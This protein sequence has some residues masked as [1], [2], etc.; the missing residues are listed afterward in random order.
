VIL[1]LCCA[2]APAVLAAQQTRNQRIAA[3]QQAYQNFDTERAL[4]LLRGA[5]NPAEGPPDSAWA[6]G[7]ELL[8]QIVSEAGD[9]A[10]AGVWFRWAFRTA[11]NIPIDTINFLPDVFRAMRGAR[12]GITASTGDAVTRTTYQWAAPGAPAGQG[13]FQVV[14]PRMTAPV[15]ALAQGRIGVQSGQTITVAAGTYQ[16]QGAAEGYLPAQITREVLPGV[17][18]V[19][20]FNL[21]PVS[22]AVLSSGAR[23]AAYRALVPLTVRRFGSDSACVTGALVSGSGLV[24]TSYAAI[25]GAERLSAAVGTQRYG[26]E[27]RVLV[28]DPARNLAVLQLPVARP[29]SLPLAA[30]VTPGQF[31]WAL[32]LAGCQTALDTRS[33]VGNAIQPALELTDS[34]RDAQHVG[35]V[36][37]SD[38][39][40]V[41]L[42]TGARAAA[43]LGDV[44]AIVDSARRQIAAREKLTAAQ[45]ALRTNHAYGS[46]AITADVTGMTARVTPLETWQWPAV[47]WSGTLPHTFAGPM[48]RYQLEL[49]APGQAPRRL[50]FTIRPG[51]AERFPVTAQV[52]GGPGPQ[53]P[54]AK[55]KGG[56]PLPI[57]LIGAGG[58]GAAAFLL[59]GGKSQ[60]QQQQQQP[61]TGSLIILI[62]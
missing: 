35:A 37:G 32:G 3:A 18:T 5:V 44:R 55:K 2:L 45:V 4:E 34:V 28:W 15:N 53:V 10:Q 20:E 11:A 8:G 36:I 43:P 46:M 62:P 47:S 14:S 52:V 60:Q 33:Q 12:A 23:A 39:A 61:T 17:T 56:F 50:T 24:L 7:I 54:A 13:R 19:L 59:L 38:G 16:I 22:A 41:G 48:G 6:Y 58:A 21:S 25:R 26:D 27:I 40:V 29:D 30:Q 1:A 9:T 42:L 51:Q 31:V 57:V 49:E